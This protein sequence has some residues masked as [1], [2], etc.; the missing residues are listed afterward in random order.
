MADD[1][2]TLS[3]PPIAPVER[4]SLKMHHLTN[5]HLT[6]MSL[7]GRTKKNHREEWCALES[8]IW[9]KIVDCLLTHMP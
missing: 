2:A 7:N 3:N 4:K 8:I 5:H 6:K 1:V 9:L